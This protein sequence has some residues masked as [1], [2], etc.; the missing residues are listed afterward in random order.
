M[1]C[2]VMLCYMTYVT[3]PDSEVHG[4]NMGPT[5]VRQDPGGTHVGHIN[6]DIWVDILQLGN[7]QYY[8]SPVTLWRFVTLNSR[9]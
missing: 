9:H 4:T 7:F 6:L 5:W 2:F 8:G 1:L 3:Y